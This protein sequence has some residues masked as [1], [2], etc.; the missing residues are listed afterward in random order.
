MFCFQSFI[1]DFSEFERAA[2]CYKNAGDLD[3]CLDMYL[4]SADCHKNSGNKFHEGKSKEM[5][6]MVAKDKGDL[7]RA[8]ALFED[9]SRLYLQSNAQDSA[10]TVLD[11]AGKILENVDTKKAIEVKF[12]VDS[13]LIVNFSF[14]RVD[15]SLFTRQTDQRPR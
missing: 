5:A 15:C 3:S 4:K 9:S 13:I 14:T 2:T 10:T 8:T 6:A 1:L 11:R 12:S 7:D